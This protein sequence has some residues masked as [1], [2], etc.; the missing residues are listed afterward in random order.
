MSQ[1][2]SF[3]GNEIFKN[4]SYN[5]PHLSTWI[6]E[7]IQ[8]TE[9][10]LPGKGNPTTDELVEA[11]SRYDACFREM[12]KQTNIFSPDLTRI[13]SKLW[14]GVLQLLDQMIKIY[15][16]HVKQTASLQDQA[17]ELIHQRQA[18]VAAT[19]IKQ[20]EDVLERTGLRANIRNLEGEIAAI[21]C[22]NREL[23]RE[24][25]AL[26]AVLET[27]IDARDFD[28]S[29]LSL[30]HEEKENA[31]EHRA[32]RN[33]SQSG[34]AH[35]EEVNRLD[36]ELNEILSSVHKEEDRQ[37]ALF[38]QLSD[39]MERNEVTL[40]AANLCSKLE[41]TVT[42]TI[43]VDVGCQVDEKVNFGVVGEIEEMAPEELPDYPPGDVPVPPQRKGLSVPFQLRS[44]MKEYPHVLRIPS[45]DYIKQEILSIYI[46][47]IRHD[48]Q[49]D[50]QMVSTGK[51]SLPEYVYH[52][53]NTLYGLP[54]LAD[55]QVMVL[56][57]ACHY[58]A[59]KSKRVHL[60]ASQL[61]IFRPDK[62]PPLDIRDTDFILVLLRSLLDQG[63][64]QPHHNHE[65]VRDQKARAAAVAAATHTNQQTNRSMTRENSRVSCDDIN[66]ARS[67][68]EEKEKGLQT[69]GVLSPYIKRASALFSA[70]AIFAKWLPDQANEYLMK[71]RAMPNVK[72]SF[73]IDLDDFIEVS[74]EQWHVVRAIWI[75]HI[76]ELYKHSSSIY[77]VVS[78]VSFATD[79]GTVEKDAVLV[80][81]IRDP[82]VQLNQRKL[83]NFV[84]AS[85]VAN[86]AAIEKRA[87]YERNLAEARQ[88]EEDALMLTSSKRR[89]SRKNRL[90]FGQDASEQR[91]PLSTVHGTHGA[92]TN[93][94]TNVG[95]SVPTHDADDHDVGNGKDNVV[96][97]LSKK[98]FTN[99]IKSMLPAL[100]HSEVMSP[101][102]YV[103]N[104]R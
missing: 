1:S 3:G 72:G 14:I 18:Q 59:N 84:E 63:E 94:T 56:L 24:N 70:Q 43:R 21:K 5:I 35:L 60:F 61:G 6:D 53:Y 64:L 25:R 83:H 87:V 20:E 45:L 31:A 98:N 102:A 79:K 2:P 78:E 42:S 96:E 100:S 65:S 68:V 57:R 67:I 80:Q 99:A 55:M 48:I 10:T 23:D 69:V 92:V 49:F 8:L 47:K 101:C 93:S 89:G 88:L 11:V 74:A 30:V 17:R 58:H 50:Q 44:L 66:T 95:A 77:R 15:H 9:H 76:N 71:V 62:P 16:R 36:V 37:L 91:R 13:Y 22:D 12:L 26:R 86:V 34:Q 82:S 28:M 39:L 7:I 40:R 41:N 85:H 104:C 75:E 97:L 46:S 19:K 103:I 51:H 73:H 33:T 52:Y 54:T 90:S 4:H 38:S 29:M 27:Y 32:K 81:M